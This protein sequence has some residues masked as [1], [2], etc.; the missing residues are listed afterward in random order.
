MWI[1]ILPERNQLRAS[2][3][4]LYFLVGMAKW[5]KTLDLPDGR[6]FFSPDQAA[7][8]LELSR[9]KI[10][11]MTRG[12]LLAPGRVGNRNMY[13]RRDLERAR[14]RLREVEIA[15]GL[16]AGLHPV[17]IYLNA[18]GRFS[19]EEVTQ[20]M[21]SWA[22]LTGAWVIEGPR[23]SY[24]RW[25]E[26]LQ[27]TRVTPRQMRRLVELLLVDDYVRRLVEVSIAVA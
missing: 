14:S 2:P 22:Q 3:K 23:G 10:E 7:E 21:A 4:I 24:A 12:G 11:R 8:F 26:R 18:E 15:R 13:T 19:L 27:V 5:T 17:D 25:L 16:Q 9:A 1:L 20:A 6:Q